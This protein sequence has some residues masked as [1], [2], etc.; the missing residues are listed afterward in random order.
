MILI[1]FMSYVLYQLFMILIMVPSALSEYYCKIC[2][3]FLSLVYQMPHMISMFG[4]PMV[5]TTLKNNIPFDCICKCNVCLCELYKGGY[6]RSITYIDI[7]GYMQEDNHLNPNL[8]FSEFKFVGHMLESHA[9]KYMQVP[10]LQY[11]CVYIPLHIIAEMVSLVQCHQIAK[12]H[13]IDINSHTSSTMMKVLFTNHTCKEC[14]S[15][16]TV[17]EILPSHKECKRIQRK[18][19]ANSNSEQRNSGDKQRS[20]QQKNIEN[21]D[22]DLTAI[23][24][25]APLDKKIMHHVISAACSTFDPIKFEEAGCAVCGQLVLMSS[26]T[27]LSAVKNYLHILEAPGITRQERHK[28]S[29]KIHEFPYAIDHLCSHICNACHAAIRCSK[30]PKMALA[31]G[32]WLGPV[33]EVLSSLRYIEKMLVARIRHSFCSIRIASGMRKMKAHAIAYQQPI[34]KVYD[35]LPPPKAEIEEVIAIM[36]T[37]PCKPT[38]TDFKRTPF[39][40]RRNHV[41][42]ALEWLILNHADYENVIFSSDNLQEYPEDMPPVSIEYKTMTHNKT[43]EATSVHDMEMRMALKK[44]IVHLLFMA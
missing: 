15:F 17:F 44:V 9:T 19:A 13:S 29:D 28:S 5:S 7:K 20:I 41:K 36:F 39:L 35:I 10:R 33:P 27:K 38:L 11:I 43:P 18:K 26:L 6:H 16:V 34:P 2:K 12:S 42:K 3:M 1:T 22:Q 21:Y 14:M 4:V 37:G 25:P 24:P 8:A 32:L 23:F 40:V 31:R 30:V